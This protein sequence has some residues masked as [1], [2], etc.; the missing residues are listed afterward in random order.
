M[1]KIIDKTMRKKEKHK[2][3]KKIVMVKKKRG[4]LG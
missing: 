1:G 2:E 4:G 3:I